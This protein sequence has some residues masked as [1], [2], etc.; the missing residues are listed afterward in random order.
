MDQQRHGSNNGLDGD[1]KEDDVEGYREAS[2]EWIQLFQLKIADLLPAIHDELQLLAL[3][4]KIEARQEPA[5]TPS[6]P[7]SKILRPF[8]L[9]P[10]KPSPSFT[11]LQPASLA[12]ERQRLQSAV[13]GPG[14]NLPTMTIDEW[15]DKELKLGNILASSDN[16]PEQKSDDEDMDLDS[17]S[18]LAKDRAWDTF[19][20][21]NKRGWGNRMRQS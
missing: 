11:A 15:L 14:Y 17:E 5:P 12:L 19:K 21:Q 9:L 13:F 18:R 10:S 6:A 7:N 8:T 4:L 2:I 1:E 20:D 16:V 3:R